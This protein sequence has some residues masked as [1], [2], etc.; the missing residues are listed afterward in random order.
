MDDITKHYNFYPR[1]NF[2]ECD[3]GNLATHIGNDQ[4]PE[5][6]YYGIKALGISSATI[7]AI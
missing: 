7:V 6:P 3:T 5:L 4:D 2:S 1:E